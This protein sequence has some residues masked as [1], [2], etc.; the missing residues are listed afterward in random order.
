MIMIRTIIYST[1]A[2]LLM[3]FILVFNTIGYMIS[4]MAD[5]LM[6]LI[7][8]MDKDLKKRELIENHEQ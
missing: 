4:K 1:I 5:G 8:R 2:M 7:D 3:P 6:Y